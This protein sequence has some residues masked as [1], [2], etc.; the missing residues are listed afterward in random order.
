MAV[1][2]ALKLLKFNKTYKMTW[3]VVW[4]QVKTPPSARSEVITHLCFIGTLI[5]AMRYQ[6]GLNVGMSDSFAKTQAVLAIGKAGYDKEMEDV[7]YAVFS[8]EADDASKEYVSGLYAAINQMI[9]SVK[10]GACEEDQ[11]AGIIQDLRAQYE[12][13]CASTKP[14]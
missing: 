12:R 14:G 3:E 2:D 6:V 8:V 7:I 10:T 5:Y 11:A 1:R 4:A 9:K 13:L